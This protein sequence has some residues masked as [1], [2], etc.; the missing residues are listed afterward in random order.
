MAA[1]LAGHSAA[2]FIAVDDIDLAKKAAAG[3]PDNGQVRAGLALA[4]QNMG[5]MDRA[6]AVWRDLW[7]MNHAREAQPKHNS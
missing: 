6:A 4:L 1:E 5:L 3:A 7:R 2:L